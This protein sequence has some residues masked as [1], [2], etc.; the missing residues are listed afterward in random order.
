MKR[1]TLLLA[2]LLFSV[3]AFALTPAQQA[4]LKTDIQNTASLNAAV[5]ANDWYTVAD[6]YNSAS[7][8]P[9]WWTACPT[10][11]IFNALTWTNYTPNDAVPTDTA[12]NS[13]VYLNRMG[14]VNIKQMNLQ[15]MVIGR[16]SINMANAQTRAGIRDATIQLPTGTGGAMTTTGGAS[17]AT[18]LAACVRPVLASR[19]EKLFS[20][21]PSTTGSVT[22]DVLTFEGQISPLDVQRA[23]GF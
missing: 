18:V 2:A 8:T 14:I 15:N 23:M 4:T 12:L 9:V 10:D 6:Y 19:V 7:S 5:T 11:N 16:T 20:A 22:A 3:G 21:G 13:A 1:F 17:G